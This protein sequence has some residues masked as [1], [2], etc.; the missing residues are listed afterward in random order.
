LL[1]RHFGTACSP[2][3]SVINYILPS[4]TYQ[5][6]KNLHS[7]SLNLLDTVTSKLMKPS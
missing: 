7:V 3:K 4:T 2:E 6:I 1:L 5:K